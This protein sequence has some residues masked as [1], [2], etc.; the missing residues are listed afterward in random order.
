MSQAWFPFLRDRVREVMATIASYANIGK[1]IG[2]NADDSVE[3]YTPEEDTP[4]SRTGSSFPTIYIS[5]PISAPL[6]VRI[7]REFHGDDDT[8]DG[9]TKETAF[10]TE[11]GAYRYNGYAFFQGKEPTFVHSGDSEVSLTAC[12]D[13]PTNVRTSWGS[14]I[15]GDHGEAFYNP[16]RR[17]AP[18]MI[19]PPGIAQPTV[20]TAYHSSTHDGFPSPDIIGLKFEPS[21][22][23]TPGQLVAAHA[24]LQCWKP[25]GKKYLPETYILANDED[26]I[27]LPL[28][29]L[30]AQSI[31]ANTDD[32][33]VVIP[34]TELAFGDRGMRMRVRGAVK[35]NFAWASP[36]ATRASALRTIVRFY[37]EVSLLES[38]M[39]FDRC[40]SDRQGSPASQ[41]VLPGGCAGWY[42]CGARGS[43]EVQGTGHWPDTPPV[44]NPAALAVEP[45]SLYSGD[46]ND[47]PENPGAGYDLA[48][49]QGT[50]RVGTSTAPG[51]ILV[52][53]SLYVVPTNGTVPA[54]AAID[55][56]GDGS[57]LNVHPNGKII[58]GIPDVGDAGAPYDG[59]GIKTRNGGRV[60][61]G[62]V[63][64]EVNTETA[65]DAIQCGGSPSDASVSVAEF[66][67]ADEN[68][69]SPFDGSRIYAD[70][71]P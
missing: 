51:K 28:A 32:W 66:E 34:A 70:Q 13:N 24:F 61:L 5:S 11:M 19:E 60:V 64:Y 1:Y 71:E 10:A 50:L 63:S 41:W 7:E 17:V 39:S 21:P 57:Q 22:N 2:P 8:G 4:G 49:T 12:F 25:S 44:T 47:D 53:R 29:A 23:W 26:T 16:V 46:E 15:L 58:V 54:P 62:G 6:D 65:S 55:V 35:E 30:W 3:V 18:L 36:E 59:K 43:V 31:S 48:I 33:R 52:R 68:L 56:N 38:W 9:A 40:V 67:A 27:W 14:V 20:L 45:D 42:N 37:H 69:W